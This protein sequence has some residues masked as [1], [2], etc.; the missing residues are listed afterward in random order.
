MRPTGDV[1]GTVHRYGGRAIRVI[2]SMTLTFSS[3]EA[4]YTSPWNAGEAIRAAGLALVVGLASKS[5]IQDSMARVPGAQPTER[6]GSNTNALRSIKTL[7]N[8]RVSPISM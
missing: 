8:P 7:L 6:C 2:I 3:S 4:R 1:V 5:W